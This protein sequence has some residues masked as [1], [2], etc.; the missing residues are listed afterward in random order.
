MFLLRKLIIVYMS[1]IDL[2][3]ANI[4]FARAFSH[5]LSDLV[6]KAAV[7]KICDVSPPSA[8]P[9]PAAMQQVLLPTC[10]GLLKADQI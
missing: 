9:Q 2:H 10:C 3:L 7:L 4:F 1:V 8:I 5:V 6:G